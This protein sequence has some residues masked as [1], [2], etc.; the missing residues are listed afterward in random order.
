MNPYANNY[1]NQYRNNQILTASQEQILLLLYDGAIRF[2][3]Q[4]IVACEAGD[5]QEKQGRISK[6]FAI[7]DE[8][9]N[10]LNHDIGGDIAIDLERLYD[11]ML[12]QLNEARREDSCDKL[13]V[14]ENL[15]IDLRATWG[16]AVEINKKEQGIIAQQLETDSEIA[17]PRLS[18]AG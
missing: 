7:I 4:A 18:V 12:R 6:T 14:V 3:R 15:L 2:C 16:E 17:M 9:S 8:F 10:S 5:H 13:K 11:F 1:S